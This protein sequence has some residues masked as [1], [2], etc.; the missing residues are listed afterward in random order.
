MKAAK[1]SSVNAD[2]VKEAGADP[3]Y[4]IFERHLY[5]IPDADIER[6]VFI[7]QI[8]HE[9]LGCLR[10]EDLCIPKALEPVI[11]DELANQ[12]NTMLVKKI[13]GCLSIE[14]FRQKSS[15]KSKKPRS[16]LSRLTKLIK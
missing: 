5:E 16:R 8:V 7:K 9:Y 14:E 13:Y 1:K 15:R 10:K 4:A 12:V 2:T 3:L 11:I 6:E